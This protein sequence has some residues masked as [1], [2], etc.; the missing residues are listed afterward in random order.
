MTEAKK[1]RNDALEEAVKLCEKQADYFRDRC[2]HVP[3]FMAHDMREAYGTEH[4]R[5]AL[6][7]IAEKIRDLKKP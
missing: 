3:S 5:N 7:E 1:I 2:N 4:K 6:L